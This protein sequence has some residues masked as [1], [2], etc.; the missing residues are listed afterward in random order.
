[1]FYSAQTSGFYSR[2][3]HGENIPADAVE[4]PQKQYEGLLEDQTIGKVIK[5]DE[6]GFPVA[7]EPA[8]P[9]VE[10][11][12]NV[13]RVDRDQRIAAVTWRYERN[14]REVRLRLKTTD[15]INTLDAYV[16]ALADVPEQA[17]FP[18]S[19]DWPVMP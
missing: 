16:Q 2:E 8:P 15:D 11:L 6:N 18:T 13:V 19:I 4:I 7:A 1:M 10:Q 17:G 14:A 3:I 5:A 9:S 12:A